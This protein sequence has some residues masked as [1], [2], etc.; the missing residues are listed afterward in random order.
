M[1]HVT[2]DYEEAFDLSQQAIMRVLNRIDSFR[3]ESALGT[4]IHRVA[5]NEALQH[6]RRK[7]RHQQITNFIDRE[8]RCSDPTSND[9]AVSLDVREALDKLPALRRQMVQLRYW[10][11]LEYAEIGRIMGVKV[12]TVAS[13][14]NRAR[15]DLRQILDYSQPV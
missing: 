1:L 4:W 13:G 8:P 3:G 11:G 5:V 2:G 10:E 14:L 15:K 12:G 6:L 7:K 9:L